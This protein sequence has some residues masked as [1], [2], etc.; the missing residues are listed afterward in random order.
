MYI[1]ADNAL[2][3]VL[4]NSV[5]SAWIC[6]VWG[7][8]ADTEIRQR[9]M[10]AHANALMEKTQTEEHLEETEKETQTQNKIVDVVMTD[11]KK[12]NNDD[13]RRWATQNDKIYR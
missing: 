10:Y 13:Q 8:R 3:W 6:Q 11:H 5:G 9:D 12:H 4:N 1:A 2:Y 7:D